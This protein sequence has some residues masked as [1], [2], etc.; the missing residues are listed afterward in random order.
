M[1]EYY[2]HYINYM[3]TWLLIICLRKPIGNLTTVKNFNLSSIKS[4]MNITNDF[5]VHY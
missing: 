1:I 4:T 3:V 5:T 2:A